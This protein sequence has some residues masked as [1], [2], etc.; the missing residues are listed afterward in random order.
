[1]QLARDGGYDLT[2]ATALVGDS[3]MD[4][5]SKI[6]RKWNGASRVLLVFGAP[7]RGL[8]EIVKDEGL[9]LA[10]VADFVVNTIPGQGTVTVRTEEALLASLALLNVHFNY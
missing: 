6:G 7:A 9:N 10:D 8:H 4:V 3:F 5:E 1:M 2:V